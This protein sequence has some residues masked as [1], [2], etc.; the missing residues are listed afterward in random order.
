M[1]GIPTHFSPSFGEAAARAGGDGA[2]APLVLGGARAHPTLPVCTRPASDGPCFAPKGTARCSPS[3]RGAFR[4]RASSFP[5]SK[6][7]T[8]LSGS[9][10]PGLNQGSALPAPALLPALPCPPGAKLHRQ[11]KKG[12]RLGTAIPCS[13]G[14]AENYRSAREENNILFTVSPGT[15]LRS[16]QVLAHRL[17]RSAEMQNPA[18][19]IITHSSPRLCQSPAP[20]PV[21]APVPTPAPVPAPAL[22]STVSPGCPR[23]QAGRGWG[24]PASGRCRQTKAVCCEQRVTVPPQAAGVGLA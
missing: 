16:E 11:G 23:G 9:C 24:P 1:P 19:S 20:V 3:A 6:V 21:P 22:A 4:C 15:C 2:Q 8:R 5:R 17:W 13:C 18:A 12:V 10:T 14:L 7:C